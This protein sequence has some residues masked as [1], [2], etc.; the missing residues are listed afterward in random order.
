MNKKAI[1]LLL[2]LTFI[3]VVL[4]FFLDS[5]TDFDIKNQ[6]IKS[7]VY[8]G[9]LI[10]TPVVLLWNFRVIK[11]KKWQKAGRFVP[12]FVLGAL[13]FM[14]PL[15]FFS[16]SRSWKTQIIILQDKHSST[17][18]IEFQLQDMGARGYNKRTVEVQYLTDF[19]MIAH[20]VARNFVADENW[21]KIDKVVN[22]LN[23]K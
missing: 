5:L 14:E 22:E 13:L 8:F 18:K 6:F 2:N 12:V 9:I 23:L 4:L 17:H 1:S 10:L 3:S 11:E 15:R 21:L 16:A 19:F 7:F 20:P